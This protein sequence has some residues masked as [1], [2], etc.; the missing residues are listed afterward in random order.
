[1]RPSGLV[2]G[3]QAVG[4]HNSPLGEVSCAAHTILLPASIVP[5]KP[6]LK[7][8]SRGPIPDAG[9]E[10]EFIYGGQEPAMALEIGQ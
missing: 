10:L 8:Y 6:V 9:S 4:V 1:M 5:R 2:T 7:T 3:G